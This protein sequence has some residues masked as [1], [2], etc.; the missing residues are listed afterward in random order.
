MADLAV[1]DEDCR[2]LDE[3]EVVGDLLVPADE[4]AAEAV[5]PTVRDFDDPTTRG[6]AVG[7]VG[8]RQRPFRGRFGR[9]VRGIAVAGGRF[10]AGRIVVAA[11]QTKVT[12]GARCGWGHGQGQCAKQGV[13]LLHV[14]AIGLADDHGERNPRPIRQQVALGPALPTVSRVTPGGFRRTGPPF[15]PSGALTKQPSADCQCQSSPIASSYTSSKRAHARSRHP[16][17]THSWKRAWTV[18]LAPNARGNVAHCPPVRASQ[19]SPSNIARSS[20]RGRPGFL[21]TLLTCN[22]GCSSAHK[23]SSTRQIVGSS[24]CVILPP[25]RHTRHTPAHLPILLH[26]CLPG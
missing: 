1:E 26:L 6:V 9:D 8:R 5:E 21:R 2:E 17:A 14:V 15:L 4:Q 18:D 16:D 24:R 10:A 23:A 12:C 19:I 3:A 11:V 25:P 13:E 7:M 22:N 20:S